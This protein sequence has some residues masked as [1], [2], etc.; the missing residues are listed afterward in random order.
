[1]NIQY[2]I[3]HIIEDRLEQAD[4]LSIDQLC[5]LANLAATASFPVGGNYV[6]DHIH[7]PSGEVVPATLA[8]L[9]SKMQNP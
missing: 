3:R 7:G 1:M 2:R 8:T 9:M 4:S 6:P 5:Q